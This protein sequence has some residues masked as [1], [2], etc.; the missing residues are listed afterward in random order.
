VN[1]TGADDTS[2]PFSFQ[3]F[4]CLVSRNLALKDGKSVNNGGARYCFDGAYAGY[5]AETLARRLAAMCRMYNDYG[6]AA[7]DKAEANLNSLDFT[8]FHYDEAKAAGV[9]SSDAKTN[10]T[11]GLNG[12]HVNGNGHKK[13]TDVDE[14]NE[15]MRKEH[16]MAISE[17]EREGMEHALRRLEEV[18]P[19]KTAIDMLRVFIDVT[20]TFGLIYVQKDIASTRMKK[21]AK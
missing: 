13:K 6:S 4:A 19:S 18:V 8:E 15:K 20:D 17:F 14:L 21:E 10:G 1:T 2:C 12:E 5:V 7:R 3:F 9:A 11:N 16:L